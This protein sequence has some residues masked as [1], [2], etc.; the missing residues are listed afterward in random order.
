VPVTQETITQFFVD[1]NCQVDESLVQEL[2][3]ELCTSHPIQLVIGKE[4]PLSTAWRRNKYYRSKFCVVEPV[5]YVIDRRNRRS[6]QYIP[7]LKTLQQVLN[8]ETILSNAVNLKEKLQPVSSERQV[9]RCLWDGANFKENSLFSNEC[10]VSLILYIDDFE[11]CNPLGTSRKIHKICAIY[12]ILGNLPPGSHSSLSSIYLAA[13]I[14]SDDVK[15]YGYNAVLEPLINDIIILEQH[16]IFVAKLGK[17]VKGTVQCVVADNL[18]A[19]SLAGFVESFSSA[20]V[21]RFCTAQKLDFQTR[22]VGS[23]AFSLRTEEGHARHLKTLEEESLANC[24]GVKRRCVLSEKLAHFNVTTGFPPDIVH[25]LFEGIVPREIALCLSVFTS[26]KY[27]TL[28]F[29]NDSIKTFPFKWTDKTNCPHPVPLT[30]STRRTVGGNSHENWSLIRFLPLLLGQKVPAD[31]PAWNL[32][33]D[34]KDIVDLVVTPVHTDETI[35][36]LN[37]KI[38]EHRVRFKEVFPDSN[39]LPKHHFLEHYPQLIYQFGPLVSLWT[40]RFEAKHSF[41]KRVVRHTSCFKNLLLSLAERHQLSMAHQLYSCSFPKP[42]LEVKKFSTVSI[43]VLKDDIAQA[44]KHKNPNV[45]EV[46]LAKNVIYNG[47]NYRLGMILAHGSIEGM[48]A[49]TEIIQ[50]VVLKKELVFIVRKLSSW[51]MEH[52]RA[53]QLEISPSKEI[54]VLEASQLTDPY[55]LADYTVGAMRLIT[56]KRYIQV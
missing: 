30:Y 7:V 43:D 52:Y 24:F 38:S 22:D 54:E 17:C 2:A 12:W 32:L 16:G 44:V 15:L 45:K 50:M 9:Y 20:Y 46:S 34:L 4:G 51:Y 28:E 19:H 14:K 3:T 41:F 42:L 21:C 5:E 18:G 1:H 39:L 26:K 23:G 47:F 35:A 29:L 49:F 6:F 37:F 13:L 8:C 10:A 36:Y 27:F 48:P 40:L 33:T 56:L 31:E 55:P 11:A 25:D 53:Y